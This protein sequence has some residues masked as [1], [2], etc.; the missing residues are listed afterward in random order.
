MALEKRK[1]PLIEGVIAVS[2]HHM[3]GPGHIPLI[4]W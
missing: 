3:A 2:R 4:T 1:H